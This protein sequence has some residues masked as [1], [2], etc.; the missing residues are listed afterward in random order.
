MGNRLAQSRRSTGLHQPP[1]QRRTN[2]RL[3][4]PTSPTSMSGAP[5]WCGWKFPTPPS[6]PIDSDLTTLVFSRLHGAPRN[7]LYPPLGPSTSVWSPPPLSAA[8]SPASRAREL[9]N[10]LS[11]PSK[12]PNAPPTWPSVKNH[13]P[14]RSAVAR[15]R[16]DSPADP[17]HHVLV[18]TQPARHPRHLHQWTG[19]P[20]QRPG[21][22]AKSPTP[23]LARRKALSTDSERPFWRPPAAGRTYRLRSTNPVPLTTPLTASSWKPKP[24]LTPEQVK[25]ITRRRRGQCPYRG[26]ARGGSAASVSATGSRTTAQTH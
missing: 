3:D 15:A 25:A 1:A 21:H 8:I 24:E 14:H 5:A 6:A 22:S 7:P 2:R 18:R 4:L 17:T 12:P 13:P 20:S 26:S 19:R 9:V 16:V 23:P 11:T 10:D